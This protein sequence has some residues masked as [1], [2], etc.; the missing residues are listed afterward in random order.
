M[1]PDSTTAPGQTDRSRDWVCRVA[2]F[3]EHGEL[4]RYVEMPYGDY[5]A[6][7]WWQFRRLRYLTHHWT[8]EE[9]GSVPPQV[10]HLS[11]DHLGC[12][13]D[14]DLK[15]LCDGCHVKATEAARAARRRP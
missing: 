2:R 5:L 12:E 8:C 11:Y 4:R 1:R 3:D 13:P 10:H 7:P 15:T 9:C 14:D 6:S